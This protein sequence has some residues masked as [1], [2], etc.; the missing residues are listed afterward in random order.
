MNIFHISVSRYI[1][2]F[3]A[4]EHKQ[5]ICAAWKISKMSTFQG[6]EKK[7]P[8]CHCNFNWVSKQINGLFAFIIMNF[9]KYLSDAAD[10]E[11]QQT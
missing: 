11:S 3:Y 4:L 10:Q 6:T 5:A 8:W 9:I 2:L 7:Q 1:K